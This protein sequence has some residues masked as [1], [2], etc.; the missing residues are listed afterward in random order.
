MCGGCRNCGDKPCCDPR[1]EF[2]PSHLPVDL[3]GWRQRE[4]Q[5]LPLLPVA[6]HKLPT[7]TRKGDKLTATGKESEF[8]H[9]V[10]RAVVERDVKTATFLKKLQCKCATSS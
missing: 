5:Y 3:K 7:F 8:S 6:H 10:L 2:T 1:D 9:I 4:G